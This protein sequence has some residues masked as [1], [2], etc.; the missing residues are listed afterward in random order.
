MCGD[1]CD[2]IHKQGHSDLH[3]SLE[4][5]CTLRELTYAATNPHLLS[6]PTD[7]SISL[8]FTV[9]AAMTL[10]RRAQRPSPTCSPSIKR[11]PASSTLPQIHIC[12]QGPL[13]PLFEP[14]SQPKREPTRCRGR[15]APFRG[16]EDEHHP[17]ERQVRHCTPFSFR[18]GPMTLS[19]PSLLLH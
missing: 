11:S 15:Q 9:S 3:A 2:R 13:T 7:T 17:H 16:A 18:Q 19:L 14:P 10:R 5:N 12:C 8:A 4:T 1:M 6:R